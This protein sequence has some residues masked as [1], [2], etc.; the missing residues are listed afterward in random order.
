[1]NNMSLTIVT[2]LHYNVIVRDTLEY[3]IEK[4]TYAKPAYEMKKKA[5]MIEIEKPTALKQFMDSNKEIG[6]RIEDEVKALYAAVYADD[7]TICRVANE[8]LRVD[9]SQHLAIYDTVLPLHEDV[10]KSIDGHLGFA[11]SKNLLEDELVKLVVADER[12]YRLLAFHCLYN[13]LEKLFIEYNKARNEAKGEITPQS[14]F[15]QGELQ[16]IGKHIIFIRDHLAATD[17][18][19]WDV[20][21]YCTKTIDWTSGRRQL[22][23]G[24]KFQECFADGRK[25]IAENLKKAEDAWKPLYESAVNQLIEESKKANGQI[26]LNVENKEAK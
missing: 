21:D 3:A 2:L 5:V 19:I 12:M 20:A 23:A 16:R 13:D 18:E 26:K 17:N 8:E 4:P 25:L 6:K 14:N 10:K 15:V 24:K 22:P 9:A 1:M 11:R 7:N